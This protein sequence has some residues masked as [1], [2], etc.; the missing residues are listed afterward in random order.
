MSDLCQFCGGPLP[1]DAHH[2][3]RYCSNHCRTHGY[4]KVTRDW[5]RGNEKRPGPA[6]ID[7]VQVVLERNTPET[8]CRHLGAFVR[9]MCRTCLLMSWEIA[10]IAHRRATQ[11]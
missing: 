4:N 5:R 11:A 9:D 1:H 6:S 7:P 8:D 2:N 3:D 10:E